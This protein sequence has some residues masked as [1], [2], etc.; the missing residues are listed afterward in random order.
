MHK[1]II[2]LLIHTIVLLLSVNGFS[3][4]I[5]FKNPISPSPTAAE[6]GKYA[7]WPV[8]YFH[9]LAQISIP[10]YNLEAGN[11]MLPISLSYHGSGIKVDQ[12]ATW[13]GLGWSLNAGGVITCQVK[14]VSD[15]EEDFN[16]PSL[17]DMQALSW[18]Y[19][20]EHND[21]SV[22]ELLHNITHLDCEPDVYS[23]NFCGYSGRFVFERPYNWNI[24][25]LNNADGLKLLEMNKAGDVISFSFVDKMGIVYEFNEYEKSNYLF[26]NFDIKDQSYFTSPVAGSFSG[27]INN[28]QNDVISAFYLTKIR[29]TNGI[30]IEFQYQNNNTFTIYGYSGALYEFYSSNNT[31]WRGGKTSDYGVGRINACYVQS[32]V[33]TKILTNNGI[34]IEFDAS[35]LRQDIVPALGG[36]YATKNANGCSLNNIYLKYNGVRVKKW[37]FN[38]GYFNSSIHVNDVADITSSSQSLE[39]RLKLISLSEYG[40]TDVDA[41]THAFSYY[42]DKEM[43]FRF[44]FTGKDKFGYCN[45][46]NILYNEA[47]KSKNLFHNQSGAINQSDN[48]ISRLPNTIWYNRCGEAI[49]PSADDGVMCMMNF[50]NNTV[51]SYSFNFNGGRDGEPNINFAKINSLKRITYPTGGYSEFEYELNKYYLVCNENETSF[52]YFPIEDDTPDGSLAYKYGGGLRIKQIN[53]NDGTQDLYKR[54]NYAQWGVVTYEANWAQKSKSDDAIADGIYCT[55]NTLNITPITSSGVM[56]AKVIEEVP[57]GK[58]IY[59]YNSPIEYPSEFNVHHYGFTE[60]Q[61]VTYPDYFYVNPYKN[62]EFTTNYGHFSHGPYVISAPVM[63]FSDCMVN[64]DYIWGKIKSK[65]IFNENND[66]IHVFK[67]EYDIKEYESIFGLR[68]HRHS[69]QSVSSREEHDRFGIYEMI[70]AKAFPRLEKEISYFYNENGTQSSVEV[71][72]TYIYDDIHELLKEQ[73]TLTSDNILIKKTFRYP[74]EID[75]SSPIYNEMTARNMIAS[76]VQQTI[77]RAGKVSD[78]QLTTYKNTNGFYVPD[79]FYKL[80]TTSPLS[81]ITSYN[82]TPLSIDTN[83][84]NPELVIDEYDN[85]GNVLKTNAADGIVTN[86]IWA[87]NQNYIVAKIIGGADF[88]LSA[89]LYEAINN[90]SF[91]GTGT[92]TEVDADI[93][94]LKSQ[95]NTYFSSSSYQVFLYTH[96]PLVGLSSETLPNKTTTYYIFDSFGRLYEVRDHDYRLLKKQTYN[97]ANVNQ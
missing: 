20:P 59:R 76:P 86:Y 11:I 26:R 75:P 14:D 15:F 47:R 67:Y 29:A 57:T 7:D 45:T 78:S 55:I 62:I 38:Y 53:Y 25:F 24:I 36:Q 16:V 49:A 82:G 40:V 60:N 12:E 27:D 56:Y 6:L 58:I 23:Y 97:Y 10:I 80:Q 52:K 9:G 69:L 50:Y 28:P 81:G 22:S 33:L 13:V 74:F 77:Y 8:D 70:N 48:Y 43:P 17:D 21:P 63:P 84:V 61:H 35:S 87:Y 96:I 66:S 31:Y 90:R 64:H 93:A 73:E 54:F 91:S 85:K 83:Y 32:K 4:D 19:N 2:P 37:H 5:L 39:K 92:K 72:K 46:D 79:K 94:F 88:S 89:S 65:K 18:Q 3:Q 95:L 51:L 68:T 71:S 41:R 44:C 30:Y 42:D 1:I 34:S